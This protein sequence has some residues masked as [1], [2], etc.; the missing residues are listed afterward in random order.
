[1]SAFPLKSKEIRQSRLGKNYITPG[2][3]KSIKEKHR[4]ERL[5]SKWPL[6]YQQRYKIYRN[7]L[8]NTIRKAK[9]NY[10]TS[11]LNKEQG[12]SKTTWKI[13]NEILHRNKNT[14][15]PKLQSNNN[16]PACE[17]LNNHF[18]NIGRNISD[19][20]Q[21]TQ[22]TVDSLM[23][24]PANVSLYLPNTSDSEIENIVKMMKN[25][26]SGY[27]EIP[28]KVLKHVITIISPVL[29]FIINLSFR[30]GIFP[31]KLKIARVTPIFKTGDPNDVNNF[32]P[33]SVLSILSKIFERAMCTRLTAF[34]NKNELLSPNQHGFLQ[35]RSTET[36]LFSFTK[37][38]N[39]SLENK[40]H[41]IGVFLDFSKA[42]DSL[43][44]DILIKKLENIGVRGMPLK[45]FHSYL[46][47][48]KQM[49][50]YNKL[51]SSLQTVSTGVP[52]GSILG[53]LLFLVYINDM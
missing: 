36:A 10:Y 28:V 13:L 1:M 46:V 15:S 35:S 3:L 12:N 38:V 19:N 43:N 39:H 27:D 34:L 23:D 6:T 21:T 44:H 45:L 53:P 29:S 7:K 37:T 51:T 14:S 40:E 17:L 18:V 25:P 42:F 16:I 31:D 52:Q 48:R 41:T 32:R 9:D 20:A 8:N 50:A 4:L 24:Q 26:A 49:V 30:T 47:N 11:S 2:I 33:I 5:A 22:T